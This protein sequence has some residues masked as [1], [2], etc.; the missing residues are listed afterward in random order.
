LAS[1]RTTTPAA[2]VSSTAP[3]PPAPRVYHAG[4]LKDTTKDGDAARG[5]ALT[6]ADFG[7]S[8]FVMTPRSPFPYTG[9][10]D[11]AAAAYDRVLNYVGA[12]WWTRDAV[13]RHGRRTPHQ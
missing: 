9:V 11:T 6:N 3:T 8:L 12:N 5:I 4:N 7:S 13:V 1:S 2:P 10:T